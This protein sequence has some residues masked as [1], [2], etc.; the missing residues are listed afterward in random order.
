MARV[1]QGLISAETCHRPG[2]IRQT[3]PRGKKG[4]GLRYE[5]ELAK[6]LPGAIHGQWFHF[7]DRAGEGW[8]Q[9][10]IML[11]NSA[12]LIILESKYTWTQAG[13]KQIELLYKPVVARAM[14]KQTFGMVVCRTLT[15]DVAKAWI[16]RD[17][18]SAISR[19][20][21]GLPTVLHWIGSGLGPL[22]QPCTPRPLAPSLSTL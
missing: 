4:A 7:V 6:S 3:R 20:L 18:E 22:Y 10:D 1:I 15:T 11:W 21:R 2:F 13:H 9:P 17:L 14:Q 19:A 12:G 8:C 16:C 5:R